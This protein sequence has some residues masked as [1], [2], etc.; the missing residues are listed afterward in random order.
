MADD[1][2]YDPDWAE[3]QKP[4]KRKS[5]RKTKLAKK[6]TVTV[7]DLD[8]VLAESMPPADAPE[9]VITDAI[10]R[11]HKS[12]A[13]TLKKTTVVIWRV[14][15]ML[16]ALKDRKAH[17]EWGKYVKDHL[18]PRGLSE[19]TEL[20]YRKI[21]NKLTEDECRK[22][23]P[24]QAYAKAGILKKRKTSS[25]RAVRDLQEATEGLGKL[26]N[27]LAYRCKQR[28][29]ALMINDTDFEDESDI[30][31]VVQADIGFHVQLFDLLQWVLTYLGQGHERYEGVNIPALIEGQWARYTLEGNVH[32]DA[33]PEAF[34]TDE[35]RETLRGHWRVAEAER[36]RLEDDDKAIRR[37]LTVSALIDEI[38]A[39]AKKT[40]WAEPEPDSEPQS[41]AGQEGSEG[42]FK[43]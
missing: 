15:T 24:T 30:R 36:K 11:W 16:N 33:I 41:G 7:A 1:I 19:T 18:T 37:R 12:V 22:I 6:E 10:I 2:G 35:F 5:S 32:P 21:A 43:F 25:E 39:D 38:R 34:I 31:M 42:D 14:G 8:A 13:I 26:K 28:E 40:T 20:R 29:D 23:K 3:K 4:A 9:D 27:A 17:G